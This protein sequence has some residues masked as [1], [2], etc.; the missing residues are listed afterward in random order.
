M[1][2][3]AEPVLPVGVLG[4]PPIF[5][6]RI[7]V[8]DLVVVVARDRAGAEEAVGLGASKSRRKRRSLVPLGA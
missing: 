6:S 2:P 3:A 8:D 4:L 7:T 1:G 5:A